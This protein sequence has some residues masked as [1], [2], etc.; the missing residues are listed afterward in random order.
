[1]LNAQ[2]IYIY[3]IY[4]AK[5]LEVYKTVKH[6]LNNKDSIQNNFLIF[7]GSLNSFTSI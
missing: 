4:T 3:I 7:N 2:F 6:I 5:A 1:M